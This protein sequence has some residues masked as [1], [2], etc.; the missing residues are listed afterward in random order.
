MDGQVSGASQVLTLDKRDEISK[1]A[2]NFLKS[3]MDTDKQIA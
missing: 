1:Y 3:N 2:M